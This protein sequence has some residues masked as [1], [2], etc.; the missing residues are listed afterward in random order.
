MK[1]EEHPDRSTWDTS[2]VD[3]YWQMK[4]CYRGHPIRYYAN[5]TRDQGGDGKCSHCTK[6]IRL[7]MSCS[8]CSVCNEWYCNSCGSKDNSKRQRSGDQKYDEYDMDKQ[9]GY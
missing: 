1:R 4:E 8:Y 2:S 6:Y 7:G 5:I 9:A 3:P